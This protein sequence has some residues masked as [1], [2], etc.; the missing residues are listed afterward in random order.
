MRDT[1]HVCFVA[2]AHKHT[3]LQH[4]RFGSL[5]DGLRTRDV[6][7]DDH[8]LSARDRAASR[9]PPLSDRLGWMPSER[10]PCCQ[11]GW[12]LGRPSLHGQTVPSRPSSRVNAKAL[13]R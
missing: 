9:Q 4:V 6:V 7:P 11:H 1:T 13:L 10:E 12:S 2:H 8:Q 3:R 5:I